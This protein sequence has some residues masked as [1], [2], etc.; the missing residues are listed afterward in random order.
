MVW[1]KLN[2]GKYHKDTGEY[3]EAFQSRCNQLYATNM[4]L[5]LNSEKFKSAKRPLIKDRCK[6]CS[7]FKEK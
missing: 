3:E 7:M 2:N 1:L 6:V 4:Y 5:M